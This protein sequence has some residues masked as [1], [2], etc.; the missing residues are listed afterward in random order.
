[1]FC[2]EGRNIYAL[3]KNYGGILILWD[4]LFGTYEDKR[5]EETTEYGLV[6]QPMTFN[7]IK[8]QTYYYSEIW[9]RIKGLNKWQNKIQA[10]VKSPSWNP[11]SPW[12]GWYHL[13]LEVYFLFHY[14]YH[15]RLLF[16]Y[17]LFS[18]LNAQ[19]LKEPIQLGSS[20]TSHY[21]LS[22]LLLISI[23]LLRNGS[24]YGT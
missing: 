18:F 5:P 7:P 15:E 11:G 12:T 21:I 3:D 13:K 24:W 17:R 19:G 23:R 1:M 20:A 2:G 14:H 22:R 8:L 4:R 16:Q 9:Y 10:V 6:F